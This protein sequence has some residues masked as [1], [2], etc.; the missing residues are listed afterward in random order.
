MLNTRSLTIA[1]PRDKLTAWI[2]DIQM[3]KRSK[4]SL[5]KML[6]TVVGRLNHVAQALP[7]SRYFLNRLR[8][9]VD[10]LETRGANSQQYL[11]M[12][13]GRHFG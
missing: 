8:Q 13:L 9:A 10:Y 3:I 5:S 11:R 7:V 1:L 6:A 4:R 12:D 2:E